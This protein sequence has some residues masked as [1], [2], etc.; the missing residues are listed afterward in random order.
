MI[1]NLTLE[2]NDK[3][4][5]NPYIC[6]KLAINVIVTSGLPPIIISI[7]NTFYFGKC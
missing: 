6:Q 5:P 2:F 7:L 3:M 1:S 4:V